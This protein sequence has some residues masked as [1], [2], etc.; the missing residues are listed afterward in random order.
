M[1]DNTTEGPKVSRRTGLKIGAVVAGALMLGREV[2]NYAQKSVDTPWG[3]FYPLYER[4]DIGIEAE[5]IP[6]NLD[7]FFMELA[8]RG[9][10]FNQQPTELFNTRY[11]DQPDG[12][13]NIEFPT[14]QK[15]AQNH[16]KVIYGDMLP[17]FD[18][19]ILIAETQQNSLTRIGIGFAV[20]ATGLMYNLV[21]NTL[22]KILHLKPSE[23]AISRRKFLR[24]T[25]AATALIIEA[26]AIKGLMNL[27]ESL[28]FATFDQKNAIERIIQRVGTLVTVA[29]PEDHLIFF[30]SVVMVDK[31]LTV[32]EVMQAEKKD[33]PGI[34]FDVG[35]DH[36]IM[37]DLLTAGHDFTRL[38]LANYP[39]DFL[40]FVCETAGGVE[41]FTTARV[42][43][44]NPVLNKEDVDLG[45]DQQVVTKEDKIVDFPLQRML[46][47]RLAA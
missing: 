17:A 30:R 36:S 35:A 28:A 19:N 34:A 12:R 15:L 33:K 41:N 23:Q 13:R 37:E 10:D 24:K 39:K 1:E 40:K 14:L 8:L 9:R 32:A 44:L 3:T 42:F 5:N 43:S 31:I 18:H 7:G 27:G 11:L 22:D 6:S 21:T 46:N 26:P 4:H 20:G 38:I 29:V 47:S 25:V 16:T 2:K 45:R